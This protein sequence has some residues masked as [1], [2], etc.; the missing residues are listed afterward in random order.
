M[1]TSTSTCHNLQTSPSKGSPGMK[2]SRCR[3]TWVLYWRATTRCGITKGFSAHGVHCLV[4]FLMPT[5][6]THH[7]CS[8]GWDIP[9]DTPRWRRVR[10]QQPWALQ[11]KTYWQPAGGGQSV[12][13]PP[14]SC[15]G[16]SGRGPR[17]RR[18]LYLRLGLGTRVTPAESPARGVPSVW[19]PSSGDHCTAGH[20]PHPGRASMGPAPPHA[21][22]PQS[23][24]V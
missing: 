14:H 23:L 2:G 6:A 7:A 8:N 10:C 9:G 24:F 11:A 3:H 22:H 21:V 15:C 16:T 19:H 4:W 13:D 12:R 17:G 5:R 20:P 18:T 1:G